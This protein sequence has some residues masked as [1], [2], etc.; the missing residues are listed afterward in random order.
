[1]RRLVHPRSLACITDDNRDFFHELFARDVRRPLDGPFR[2]A[3]VA[4]LSAAAPPLIPSELGAYPVPPTHR[5]Q[6]DVTTGP[7]SSVTVIRDLKVHD[8]VWLVVVPCPTA[9]GLEVFRAA[10][11]RTAEQETRA[12]ALVEELREPLRSELTSLLREG[13]RVDAMKRY[14][15]ASGEDL[16]MAK[17]VVDLLAPPQ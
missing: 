9:E 3:S 7:T 14:S 4:I 2:V 6:I 13:R 11:R 1:M 16:T 10:T 17:R 12:T 5:I 8:G 15:E